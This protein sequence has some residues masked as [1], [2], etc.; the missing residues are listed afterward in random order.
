LRERLG[1]LPLLAH[2]FLEKYSRELNK[3][4]WKISSYALDILSQYDFPGNVR[5]L[6]NIIQRSVALEQ[7]NI[8]LPDSLT[9][10]SFKRQRSFV[11]TPPMRLPALRP[12]SAAQEA[13]ARPPLEEGPASEER[14]GSPA[15][16]A[17]EIEPGGRREALIQEHGLSERQ[18]KAL[19]HI[20]E[21][22]SL[23]IQ[24]FEHLCPEVNRRTLQR[25]LKTMLDQGLLVTEGE[26]HHLL[27]RLAKPI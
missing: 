27:Y 20:L 2:N 16:A 9:L 10:G 21:H 5:E 25:D 23:T 3:N 12:T 13:G 15:E 1:D 17:A 4:V 7:S 26:T 24:D 22:G 19:E 18:I 14:R 11:D 6:E 8:I